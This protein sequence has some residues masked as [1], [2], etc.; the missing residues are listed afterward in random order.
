MD[1]ASARSDSGGF[2]YE[3][4]APAGD[5]QL[6]AGTVALSAAA[7]SV[8][9]E[10]QKQNEDLATRQ[11]A[12]AALEE[13]DRERLRSRANAA[14]ASL[15]PPRA[16]VQPA[17]EPPPAPR[18]LEQRAQVYL[19]IGLDEAVTQLG[20]PVHV[21]EG[22]TPEFIGLTPGR[23]VPVQIPTGRSCGWCIWTRGRM[24]LLDQQRLRGPARR[25]ARRRG[26]C[27]GLRE[28]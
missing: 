24:I 13:L 19:R 17:A 16:E 2:A 4:S 21:I 23:L 1:S 7:D 9:S 25:P 26:I 6:A 20:R 8:F 10:P 15:P 5:A 14:T 28:T 18:T 12:A 22:M 11:A 27:G 3:D